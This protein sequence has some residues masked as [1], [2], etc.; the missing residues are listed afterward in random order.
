MEPE[1]RKEVI[2]ERFDQ[3]PTPGAFHSDLLLSGIL[4]ASPPEYMK[5]DR[6]LEDNPEFKDEFVDTRRFYPYDRYGPVPLPGGDMR[7]HYH[8]DRYGTLPRPDDNNEPRFPRRRYGTLPRPD[9]DDNHDFDRRRY[10]PLPRPERYD[11]HHPYRR[12]ERTPRPERFDR[13]FRD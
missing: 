9:D 2:R 4:M 13:R 5:I 7:R 10:G 8:F 11:R 1:A 12:Y 3:L 6:P